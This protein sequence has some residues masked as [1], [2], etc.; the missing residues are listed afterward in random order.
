MTPDEAAEHID[1]CEG[2]NLDRGE[3]RRDKGRACCAARAILGHEWDAN[4]GEWI[5][6]GKGTDHV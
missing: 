4:A 5:T 3:G 2:R 1:W 6:K